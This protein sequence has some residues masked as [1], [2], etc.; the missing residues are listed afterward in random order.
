M[1]NQTEEVNE[2]P[3]QLRLGLELQ[4]L[5]INNVQ[6][7]KAQSGSEGGTEEQVLFQEEWSKIESAVQKL[8]EIYR[9]KKLVE[10]I[11]KRRPGGQPISNGKIDVIKHMHSTGHTVKQIA[12]TVKVS[13]QTVQKY[14]P[15]H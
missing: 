2:V 8:E 11:V 6:L 1:F 10:Q 13:K 3:S 7:R 14:I 15:V 9:P 5:V 4:Q 12:D